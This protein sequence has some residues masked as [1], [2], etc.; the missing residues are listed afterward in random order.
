MEKSVTK[1]SKTTL[2]KNSGSGSNRPSNNSQRKKSNNKI[3]G[4]KNS[5][6]QLLIEMINEITK[7][8][9]LDTLLTTT[10][11]TRDFTNF[12]LQLKKKGNQKA[13]KN[14]IYNYC[15]KNSP[16]ITGE[17]L[18]YLIT[19]KKLFESYHL[20]DIF[21]GLGSL[22]KLC[23]L[24]R[25]SEEPEIIV[26]R[27]DKILSL[28][29]TQF[30]KDKRSKFIANSIYEGFT[31]FQKF[32]EL[33]FGIIDLDE[34]TFKKV[35]ETLSSEIKPGYCLLHNIFDILSKTES[36]YDERRRLLDDIHLSIDELP[37]SLIELSKK[38]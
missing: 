37:E 5:P 3:S 15:L 13:N 8:L 32:R 34:D 6:K 30:N 18:Y 35:F 33:I 20:G 24:F 1:T 7:N 28:L 14:T 16:N 21:I 29:S 25:K 27:V 11:A 17:Q 22:D 38:H 9:D 19:L 12:K 2:K 4:A 36:Y 26:D 23:D 31:G 10:R